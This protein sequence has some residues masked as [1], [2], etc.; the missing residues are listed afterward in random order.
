MFMLVSHLNP[1]Q[2][3]PP[4]ETFDA[5]HY[6]FFGNLAGAEDG[7]DGALEVRCGQQPPPVQQ[8]LSQATK[9]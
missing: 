2:V 6:S 9:Y 1:L 5:A 4:G 8:Q 7:L 3:D